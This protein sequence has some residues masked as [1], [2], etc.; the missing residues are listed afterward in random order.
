M[1]VHR[2]VLVLG[3]ARSGK[4]RI[5]QKLAESAS[6]QRT[7][8]ATAQ[9]FDE[10]MGERI[11][12]HRREREDGSWRTVDAPL[13]LAEA[14]EAQAGPAGVVL[15]D[16][17]TLWLS[18]MVLAE[19][20]PERESARLIQAVRDAQGPVILVSNEVGQGIVPATPLGRRFRDA[21]GRLNQRVAEA[22]DAVV[23]VAAGCPILLKP[24][25]PLDLRLG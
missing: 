23:F 21:Q 14:I 16:C 13:A 17:L 3:G 19:R 6:P 22:C 24:A 12:Q 2:R 18:N 8:I 9:A 11:A 20:D 10:E 25:A 1:I 7:Y 15:V 5:A 4:S